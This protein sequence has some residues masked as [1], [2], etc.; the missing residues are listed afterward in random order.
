MMQRSAK[1]KYRMAS[2]SIASRYGAFGAPRTR[3]ASGYR[4]DSQS[5]FSQS[6]RP[7]FTA[8]WESA[9]ETPARST[10]S[11]ASGTT[12]SIDSEIQS[13]SDFWRINAQGSKFGTANAC[14][15]TLS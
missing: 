6:G 9:L 3:I 5:I 14:G 1:R 15:E 7:L 10:P 13:M 12:M 2:I 4:L 11:R 8:L